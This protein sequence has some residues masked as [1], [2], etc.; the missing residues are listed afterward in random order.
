[1]KVPTIWGSW[2]QKSCQHKF[3]TPFCNL[4]LYFYVFTAFPHKTVKK[5]TLCNNL[6]FFFVCVFRIYILWKW[7]SLNIIFTKRFHNAW[8]ILFLNFF[9]HEHFPKFGRDFLTPPNTIF[10]HKAQVPMQNAIIFCD[11]NFARNTRNHLCN[12]HS[13]YSNLPP[14]KKLRL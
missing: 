12:R 13:R 8:H 2:I 6:I 1:M 9:F 3:L 7:K 11:A 4:K 10:I 5:N 14:S